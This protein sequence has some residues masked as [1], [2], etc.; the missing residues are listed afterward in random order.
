MSIVCSG[1]LELKSTVSALQGSGPVYFNLSELNVTSVFGIVKGVNGLPNIKLSR[2]L[3]DVSNNSFSIKFID[4]SDIFK[5]L[6]KFKDFILKTLLKWV[7]GEMTVKE[8]EIIEK[9]FNK[10]MN[11]INPLI[12]INNTDI[13]INY[14]L[15][16]SP[17]ITTHLPLLLN[18]TGDCIDPKKCK[19]Y[20]GKRP[21]RPEAIDPFDGS[22]SL[23]VLVSDYLLSTVTIANLERGLLSFTVTSE[24]VEKTFGVKLDTDL[25]GVVVPE[26]KKAYGAGKEVIVEVITDEAS[27][28]YFSAAK[29]IQGNTLLLMN[30]RNEN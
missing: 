25:V 1:N 23:I 30:R 26:I 12:M 24:I 4:N 18:G 9:S 19:P 28:F 5:A 15:L 3:T 20:K 13:G 22:G 14:G 6:T 17:K 10:V 2:V 29:G 8:K 21:D 11:D 16:A 7:Q 27:S